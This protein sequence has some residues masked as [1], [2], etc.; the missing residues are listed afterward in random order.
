MTNNFVPLNEIIPIIRDKKLPP[1][2]EATFHDIDVYEDKN[3]IWIVYGF[4]FKSEIEKETKLDD[5]KKFN[6]EVKEEISKLEGVEKIE[7]VHRGRGIPIRMNNKYSSLDKP[8]TYNFELICKIDPELIE[9]YRNSNK[10]N[11]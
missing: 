11:L 1:R 2:R 7:I 6:S 8:G 3:I 5:I 10:F 4:K 9:I